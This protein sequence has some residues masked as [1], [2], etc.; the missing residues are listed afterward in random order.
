MWS[1][2]NYCKEANYGYVKIVR[3]SRLGIKYMISSAQTDV[4]QNGLKWNKE[5]LPSAKYS[6][7]SI[8]G[9]AWISHTCLYIH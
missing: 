9:G 1:Q 5:L 4:N 7:Q 8:Y 2:E 6:N 3:V